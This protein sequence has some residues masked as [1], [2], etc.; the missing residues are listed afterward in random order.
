[1]SLEKLFSEAKD[2]LG[3]KPLDEADVVKY[4]YIYSDKD[5]VGITLWLANFIIFEDMHHSKFKT[6]YT[7]YDGNWENNM[8]DCHIFLARE[9]I[10]KK[11][12]KFM[13]VEP[14][15]TEL[16]NLFYRSYFFPLNFPIKKLDP[17]CKVY[18][19]KKGKIVL[20]PNDDPKYKPI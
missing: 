19:Y 5:L 7:E 2:F 1:M 4:N 3:I 12:E 14:L 16:E 9:N 18:E 17:L 8:V 6:L 13:T 10:F 20:C 11:D 15:F